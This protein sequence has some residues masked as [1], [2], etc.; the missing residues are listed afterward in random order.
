MYNT[1]TYIY[2]FGGALREEVKELERFPFRIGVQARETVASQSNMKTKKKKRKRMR[3]F[4][5]FYSFLP[6]HCVR[7]SWAAVL[8]PFAITNIFV[9]SENVTISVHQEQAPQG[10]IT[11]A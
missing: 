6:H 5:V 4:I 7:Q 10:Q 1:H 9:D 2:I 11:H 3:L 8:L